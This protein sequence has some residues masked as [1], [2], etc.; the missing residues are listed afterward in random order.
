VTG[1]PA[2]SV[3]RTRVSAGLS[4]SL[5]TKLRAGVR[6][7]LEEVRELGLWML[8]GVLLGTAVETF[9]YRRRSGPRIAHREREVRKASGRWPTLAPLW[10]RKIRLAAGGHLEH[11]P[12]AG[13][14]VMPDPADQ[15]VP[16]HASCD[17]RKLLDLPLRDPV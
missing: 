12:H 17:E 2:A 14:R 13:L 5:K 1:R 8:L 6:F 11:V 15:R 9:T 7:A 4:V 10:N 3:T 16:P